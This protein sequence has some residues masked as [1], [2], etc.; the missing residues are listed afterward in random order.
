MKKFC[1]HLFAY[2]F[3]SSYAFA[4][5]PED[6]SPHVI[7]EE[8]T[9]ADKYPAPW[10]TGPLLTPSGHVIPYGYYDVEP[11]FFYNTV[12]GE[13]DSDWDSSSIPHDFTV[14]NVQVPVFIGITEWMNFLF[15]PSV[16]WNSTEGISDFVFND[17]VFEADVQ[18]IHDTEENSLPGLKIYAQELFPSGHYQKRDPDKLGTDIGGRGTYETTLGFVVTRLHHVYKTQY[19]AW[20]LNGFW[21]I[22]CK[23]DVKGINAYGGAPD[24]DA[25]VKPGQ[26]YGLL[27]GVEYSLSQNWALACDAFAVYHNKTSFTGFPGTED[28]M[29]ADLGNP[30]SF[31][32]SLA[33]AIEYMFSERLG[34]IGGVWF[35]LAGR[36]TDR[37]VNGVIAVNY[38][39]E[40]RSAPEHKFRS[41]GGGASP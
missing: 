8:L 11:Y 37:F 27:G 23:V 40:Y 26:T 16:S 30:S 10:F 13:Y 14:A 34:V 24:T 6:S 4:V 39:G 38:F 17:F 19:F 33:P 29:P 18:I 32:F 7:V 28:G 25:R 20:R 3:L 12:N 22:P 1:H 15:V 5:G 31:Q 36:N 35:T 9:P 41:S 21:R 2:C